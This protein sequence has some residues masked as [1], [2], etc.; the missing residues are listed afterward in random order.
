MLCEGIEFGGVPVN[1]D[2]DLREG[3]GVRRVCALSVDCGGNVGFVIL[4]I[5][6]LSEAQ[7]NARRG[8]SKSGHTFP[9]QQLGNICR[10]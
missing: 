6:T 8:T 4:G 10:T 9:S 7:V 1:L 2:L 3:Y 5:K